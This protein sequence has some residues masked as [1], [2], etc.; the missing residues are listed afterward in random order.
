LSRALGPAKENN[1]ALEP[2][3]GHI[4]QG[5]SGAKTEIPVNSKSSLELLSRLGSVI[6][7]VKMPGGL[8]IAFASTV[9]KK[10]QEEVIR[11][12][13]QQ[14]IAQYDAVAT[15]Y[16]ISD[17]VSR[18][19][20][21]RINPFFEKQSFAKPD[22]RCTVHVRD[23]LFQNSLYQLIDYLPRKG[24]VIGKTSRGRAWSVRY[25]II[26]RCW[27][28][29]KSDARGHVPKGEKEL[30]EQWGMAKAEAESA[31]KQTMFCYVIQG[32]NQSPIAILYL[33]A[34]PTNAFGDDTQ[35]S[36]LMTEVAKAVKDLE[37][38]NALGKV[39]KNVQA[40]APLIEIY[41]DPR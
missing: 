40:S 28:L 26:G 19:I 20:E 31:S 34:G 21:G 18:I 39:W 37:L 11:G 23:I 6:S 38:D 30:I 41:A 29:E 16:E 15:Q 13:R 22:F 17:T 8:E 12:Y 14:V 25:G 5:C 10:T 4:V 32:K 1:Y 3:D 33:D 9:V 24:A 2:L 36:D 35:M 7:N 27:R